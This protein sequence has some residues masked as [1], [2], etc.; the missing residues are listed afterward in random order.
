VSLWSG[1]TAQIN[2]RDARLR[3]VGAGELTH[4]QLDVYDTKEG[5]WNPEHG[6]LVVPD[7]WEFLPRGDAFVTRKVKA[8][9][10]YWLLWQPRG[11]NR[12]HRRL[13]GLWAPRAAVEQ[14]QALAEVTVEARGK[15]RVQSA[16]QRDRREAAYREEF[17]T[18]VRGWLDF[19]D[20][21]D[22]LAQ[23]IAQGAAERAAVVSSGRV[24]RTKK[25]PLEERAAL[26][27]RGLHPSSLHRL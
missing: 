14:A 21:F 27:A 6:E 11:R 15:R 8:G 5:P 1:F 7:D 2:T 12:P 3:N 4:L 23:E 22:Q 18:A 19:T 26:A 25:L 24:G 10:I 9:G 16:R 17:V 20:E 13:L